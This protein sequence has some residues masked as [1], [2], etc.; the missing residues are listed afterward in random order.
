MAP[1]IRANAALE[2]ARRRDLQLLFFRSKYAWIA[3]FTMRLNA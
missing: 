2:Y 1:A 3:G